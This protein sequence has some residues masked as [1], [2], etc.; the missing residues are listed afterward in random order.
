MQLSSS[1]EVPL[2]LSILCLVDM[3]CSGDAPRRS[4]SRYR[5]SWRDRWRVAVGRARLR[6]RAVSPA[7]RLS[8]LPANRNNELRTK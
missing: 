6:R 3:V 5:W 8:D 2:N 1:E 7:D 4:V